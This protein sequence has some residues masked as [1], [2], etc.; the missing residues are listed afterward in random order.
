MKA[1]VV[2][3]IFDYAAQEP[4]EDEVMVFRTSKPE[5]EIV[6]SEGFLEYGCYPVIK[7]IDPFFYELLIEND[8]RV[9]Y[10]PDSK[11]NKIEF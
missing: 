8:Y 10:I 6:D 11:A 7:A 1:T 9:T 5:S 2:I 4:G 3:Q